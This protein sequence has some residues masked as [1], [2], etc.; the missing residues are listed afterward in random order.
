[1]R[2][3]VQAPGPHRI[4]NF[5]AS[6]AARFAPSETIGLNVMV[7]AGSRTSR[8]PCPGDPQSVS[9]AQSALPSDRA[10]DNDRGTKLFSHRMNRKSVTCRIHIGCRQPKMKHRISAA[11]TD[12]RDAL[13]VADLLDLGPAELRRY[14]VYRRAD[15][16]QDRE[17]ERT[18]TAHPMKPI[19]NIL[20]SPPPISSARRN[21]TR[22][23]T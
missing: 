1:M 5:R 15:R 13:L 10:T 6:D 7:G 17:G 19:V 12:G 8:R 4:E 23:R 9:R 16:E 20:T 3:D 11:V 22:R 14:D 21:T 2:P 18:T